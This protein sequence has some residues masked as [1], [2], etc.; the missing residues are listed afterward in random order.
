MS[1]EDL[2]VAERFSAALDA[3]YASGDR[4]GVYA[5]FADEIEYTTAHRTLRGLSEVREKLEWGGELDNLD[6]ELEEGEWQDLGDGHVTRDVRLVQRWKE[7]GEV[8]A[9]MQVQVD[10]TIQNGE[11]TRYERR[12]KPE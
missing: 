3:A 9:V 2:D 1:A 4:E 10:L 6:V 8:A 7:T 11:I 5:L 12:G